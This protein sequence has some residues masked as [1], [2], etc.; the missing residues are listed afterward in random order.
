[1]SES[2]AVVERRG[3]ESAISFSLDGINTMSETQ[4]ATWK[5]A[6]SAATKKT[7]TIKLAISAITEDDIIVGDIVFSTTLLR[8]LRSEREQ[9][10][11]GDD[12]D[13]AAQAGDKESQGAFR[14][15]LGTSVSVPF[16]VL[17][18]AGTTPS[19]IGLTT[20]S[21]TSALAPSTFVGEF[22][23]QIF[24]ADNT[25]DISALSSVAIATPT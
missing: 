12:L 10:S 13:L 7:V 20:S 14:R 4:K 1:M 6:I 15:R 17:A 22:K 11:L 18:P 23:N 25:L 3:I 9:G 19:A 24:T 8:N 5:A 16:S 2:Q 21:F